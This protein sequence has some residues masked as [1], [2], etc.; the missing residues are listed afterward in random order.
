MAS[1]YVEIEK[2]WIT[3]A[4]LKLHFAI[5]TIQ[6]SALIWAQFVLIKDWD[7]QEKSAKSLD[8]DF[9]AFPSRQPLSTADKNVLRSNQKSLELAPT[10]PLC[11]LFW[12]IPRDVE[13]FGVKKLFRMHE[14][15]Y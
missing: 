11:S 1:A 13:I 5:S 4:T 14:L 12:F 7:G 6:G 9:P 8:A 15:D 10:G 2:F 3:Y